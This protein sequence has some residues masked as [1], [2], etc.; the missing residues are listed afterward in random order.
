MQRANTTQNLPRLFTAYLI[1]DRCP[2]EAIGICNSTESCVLRFT[3]H[4]H[5]VTIVIALLRSFDV[6]TEG[7][8]MSYIYMGRNRNS[9]QAVRHV[10]ANPETVE[11]LLVGNKISLQEIIK[12]DV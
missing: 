4:V 8:S 7:F 6:S 2:L 11:T 5:A 12:E 9:N 10:L 3:V 1:D